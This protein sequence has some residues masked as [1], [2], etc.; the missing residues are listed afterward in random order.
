MQNRLEIQV[1]CDAGKYGFRIGGMQGVGRRIGGCRTGQKR[2]NRDAGLEG[3]R[4]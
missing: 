4:K 2:D 3:C 1:R